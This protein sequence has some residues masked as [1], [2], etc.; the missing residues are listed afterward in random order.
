[1]VSA[2]VA[3][4]IDIG[5]LRGV[6]V[7]DPADDRLLVGAPSAQVERDPAKE[8]AHHDP[9]YQ[10]EEQCLGRVSGGARRP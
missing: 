6:L 4:E 2:A 1:M 9:R 7:D 10:L 3:V 5:P 8:D